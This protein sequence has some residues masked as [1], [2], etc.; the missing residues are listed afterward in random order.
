MDFWAI[1][2]QIL[3]IASLA[4]GVNFFVTI[5]NMRAPGHE[6]HADA[7]VRLDDASSR[8]C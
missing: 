5:L 2:L 8:S 7:G 4:A 6:A 3:G 1:G